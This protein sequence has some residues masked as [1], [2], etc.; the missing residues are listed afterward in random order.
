[1][2]ATS[3][4]RPRLLVACVATRTPRP[5]SASRRSSRIMRASSTA[6]KPVAGSS[7]SRTGGRPTSSAPHEARRLLPVGERRDPDVGAVLHLELPEHL[8]D[9]RLHLLRRSCRT[10]AAARRRSAAPRAPSAP[11]AAASRT[12]RTRR[13]WIA[14]ARNDP[15]VPPIRRTAPSPRRGSAVASIC[16]I[17]WHRSDPIIRPTGT[18][19]DAD[20]RIVC[21][22]AVTVSAR[23][24]SPSGA[25]VGET[26]VTEGTVPGGCRASRQAPLQVER[27]FLYAGTER[28]PRSTCSGAV[29]AAAHQAG[30][31][32]HQLVGPVGLLL[33]RPADRRSGGR[34]RRAD[35]ARPCPERP[36][37]RRSG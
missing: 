2:T 8:L 33:V 22:P 26:D 16:R 17:R 20:R 10:G 18:E 29:S 37:S 32:G 34:V 21:P 36:G 35:R 5:S 9:A 31:G 27:G 15:R 7:S 30:D 28:N 11:G 14:A 12:A 24:S 23:P 19:I 25:V 3:S 13:R 1:M 6:S 4:Q